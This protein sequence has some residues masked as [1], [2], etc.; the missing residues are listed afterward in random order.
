[1]RIPE[2][3]DDT[4]IDGARQEYYPLVYSTLS[5]LKCGIS[6]IPFYS[7]WDDE[8]CVTCRANHSDEVGSDFKFTPANKHISSSARVLGSVRCDMLYIV[9]KSHNCIDCIQ[10]S[11]E[12]IDEKIKIREDAMQRRRIHTPRPLSPNIT[13]ER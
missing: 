9:R 2:I 12:I 10:R 7:T 11:I 1:M 4:I 3:K 13:D 5:V 8:Y 6:L